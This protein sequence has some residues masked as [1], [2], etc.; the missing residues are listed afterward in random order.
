MRQF[1]HVHALG[2][3]AGPLQPGP[4]VS[5]VMADRSDQHRA[6][7][8]R[9]HAERDVGRHPAPA[10]LQLVDQERQ[11]KPFELITDELVGETAG[12]AHQVVGGDR[13]RHGNMH[14]ARLYLV[15]Y[16]RVTLPLSGK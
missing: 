5:E 10:D 6:Q 9:T 15:G 8:Q 16:R 4:V 13:P 2:V 7:A 3:D 14:G 12:K 1:A 11:R